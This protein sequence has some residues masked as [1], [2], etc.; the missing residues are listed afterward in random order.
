MMP[1]RSKKLSIKIT[2]EKNKF[3]DQITGRTKLEIFRA[4]IVKCK[5]NLKIFVSVIVATTVN[6]RTKHHTKAKNSFE[7]S[8]WKPQLRM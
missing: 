2:V 5:L 6:A 3:V 8:D 7:F 4:N 1:R